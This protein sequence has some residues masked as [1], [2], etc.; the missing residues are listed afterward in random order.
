MGTRAWT[1]VTALAWL[2]GSLV[3]LVLCR[4]AQAVPVQVT[5]R[6]D[7]HATD[8]IEWGQQ[9]TAS[10]VPPPSPAWVTAQL[11]GLATVAHTG[12]GPCMPTAKRRALSSW[13]TGHS[14]TA[15][16]RRDA[17][18]VPSP[19]QVRYPGRPEHF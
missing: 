14:V 1:T 4:L 7:V 2:V 10:Y 15:P 18:P 8:T 12:G 16:L 13:R 5:T 6:A 17:C 9:G 3:L 19:W 11:G